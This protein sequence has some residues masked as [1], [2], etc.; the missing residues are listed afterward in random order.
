MPEAP[1]IVHLLVESRRAAEV[2]P[3]RRLTSRFCNN[4]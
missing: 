4:V 1:A 2:D 3:Q